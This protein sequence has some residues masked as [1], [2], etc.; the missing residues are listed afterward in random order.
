MKKLLLIVFFM[1]L[2][3][4]QAFADITH[5]LP[6]N[7][8]TGGNVVNGQTIAGTAIN[9]TII[10]TG[11]T[12]TSDS[13]YETGTSSFGYSVLATIVNGTGVKE[14]YQVS[15]DN[16]N[17]FTPNT[18]NSVGV[19]TPIGT[20]D[21]LATGNNWIIYQ[22]PVSTWIRFVFTA[23]NSN[24]ATQDSVTAETVYQDWV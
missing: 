10:A 12:L 21:T 5:T 16:N 24:G 22:Y 18:T 23:A 4:S 3:F 15:Y 11:S 2:G 13:V 9:N 8:T 17:W 14:S 20:L 19:I 7:L 6:H 1:L